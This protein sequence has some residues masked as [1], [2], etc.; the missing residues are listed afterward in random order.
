MIN[1][2]VFLFSVIVAV[3]GTV[4]VFVFLILLSLLIAGMNNLLGDRER[5]QSAAAAVE[6]IRAANDDRARAVAIAL[7]YH[8]R[9]GK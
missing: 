3:L 9:E 1:Q 6:A 2:E 4:V 5:R 8:F 7:A